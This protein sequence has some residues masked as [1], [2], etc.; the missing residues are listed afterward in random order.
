MLPVLIKLCVLNTKYCSLELSCSKLWVYYISIGIYCNMCCIAQY[1]YILIHEVV[2]SFR[3]QLVKDK[4]AERARRKRQKRKSQE[5]R[6]HERALCWLWSK[7]YRYTLFCVVFFTESFCRLYC[8]ANVL[9]VCIFSLQEQPCS[10]HVVKVIIFCWTF[11]VCGY[12]NIN[13][14][15]VYIT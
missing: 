2:H 15:F 9:F 13:A 10:P 1:A 12:I 6:E 14:S 4:D 5:Q 8:C 11:C 3:Y 7:A